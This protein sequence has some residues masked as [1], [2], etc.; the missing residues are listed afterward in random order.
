MNFLHYAE[1][2][3]IGVEHEDKKPLNSIVL[4]SQVIY[5]L[6]KTAK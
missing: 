2:Q 3:K 4:N 5:S 6:E 1:H